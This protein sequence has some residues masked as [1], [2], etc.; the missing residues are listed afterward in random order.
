MDET[1]LT[2]IKNNISD[3]EIEIVIS[4]WALAL[5]EINRRIRNGKN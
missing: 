1:D 5:D 4:L 2:K 3:Y